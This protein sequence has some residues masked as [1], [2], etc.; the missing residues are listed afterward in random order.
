M[1]LIAGLFAFA[2]EASLPAALSNTLRHAVSRHPGEDVWL[3]ASERAVLA[4]VDL[5]AYGGSGWKEEAN[6]ISLLAGEPLLEGRSGECNASRSNDLAR[7]HLDLADETACLGR[8]RGV[9]AV[10][11]YDIHRRT[12]LLATDPLGVRPIYWMARDGVVTFASALRI[13]E[14]LHGSSLVMDSRAVTEIVAL[15]YPLAGRTP[16]HGVRLLGAGGVLEITSDGIR[17]H[18]YARWTDIAERRD[19]DALAA[20]AYETF[21]VGVRRRLR[22]DRRTTAFLSGGLDSRCLVTALLDEGVDVHTVN[23]SPPGSQDQILARMFAKQAGTRHEEFGRPPSPRWSTLMADAL[24]HS[25]VHRSRPPERPGV[26]WSGDG[27]SVGLGHV[28]LHPSIVAH[29]RAGSAADAT[30]EFLRRSASSVTMRLFTRPAQRKLRSAV[31]DGVL[32]ELRSLETEDPARAFL[33]FLLEN[34]QRRHLARHFEDLD[35]HRIEYQLP[36]FDWLLL[37]LAMAA[38]LDEAIGHRFY[39][40]WLDR[41]PPVA[42]SVP[43][44]AYP[45]HVGCPLPLP[46]GLSYQWEGSDRRGR[47]ARRLELHRARAA[48]AAESGF[49]DPLLRR[50]FLRA[51]AF[52][53]RFGLRDC[54][55]VL[56]AARIFH[57]NWIR[58]GGRYTLGS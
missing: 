46:S 51:A 13:I 23:F 26:V 35:L 9:F 6:A 32:E 10:A 14:G 2:D 39:V 20:E 53:H 12:L 49:P 4:K 34:D 50:S 48:L 15:G 24:H 52:A 33:V 7:L 18:R 54:T 1:S 29:M 21:Q 55:H 31:V 25:P 58:S 22:T 40:R 11:R 47:D 19:L 36:F 57:E 38:P 5:N 37:R 41:F 3:H 17:C 42:R 43:W 28:Y 56:R 30:L 8:A 16:F 27:G 45:G 44:Q